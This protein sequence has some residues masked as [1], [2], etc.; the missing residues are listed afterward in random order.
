[1]TYSGQLFLQNVCNTRNYVHNNNCYEQDITNAFRC[2]VKFK[3]GVS[4]PFGYRKTAL[5]AQGG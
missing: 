2:K 1:M 3:Q 4:P 5:I